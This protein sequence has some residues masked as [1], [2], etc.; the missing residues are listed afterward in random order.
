MH[1]PD[2]RR[3]RREPSRRPTRVKRAAGL[4]WLTGIAA[5]ILVRAVAADPLLTV[6]HEKAFG[7]YPPE[8]YETYNTRLEAYRRGP[9]EGTVRGG[10]RRYDL[11]EPVPGASEPRPL[12]ARPAADSVISIQAIEAAR[13][14][15]GAMDSSALMIWHRGAVVEA[16]YFGEIRRDTPIVSRSLAKPVTAVAI[17]RA[18]VEGY[19][20]SLDQPVADF[21][22]EWQ[23]G[24]KAAIRVR[25]LLDMRSGLLPQGFSD[26]PLS[27]FSLTY[28]HPHHEDFL[29][30]HYPLTH[31]PGTRYEYSNATSELVAVLIERATG[32]RYHDWVSTEVLAPLGAPG[33]S[34]W[35]NR[36]GG[37]AHAGCCILLPAEVWLR[38]GVLLLQ[39]GVWEGRRL[40]E[41]GFVEAMRTPTAENPHAG[42]G[43]F[44]AGPY[45][46]RR[47]SFHPD[48]ERSRAWHSEPYLAADTF[49]FDGYGNQVVYIIPSYELVILRS[50][51]SPPKQLRWD[52]VYLPNTIMRGIVMDERPAAQ[53]R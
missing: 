47:G 53:P 44:V 6:S 27:I 40:L 38:L 50:G 35:I 17:G 30:H 29:I 4:P 43:V 3:H 12:P 24:D 15:A 49:L 34:V 31:E 45:V 36:P 19:I 52:N 18:M 37:V 51:G 20:E 14:Y 26:D 39:D 2:I 21:I 28:L 48:I 42:M 10:L 11:L 16:S 22:T 8:V 7:P 25:H 9:A 13:E 23:N 46:E 33:G 32:R 1:L 41:P 5:L